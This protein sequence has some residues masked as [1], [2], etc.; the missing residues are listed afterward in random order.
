MHV[1]INYKI[2]W[3]FSFRYSGNSSLDLNASD[4]EHFLN[5]RL[6]KKAMVIHRGRTECRFHQEILKS[7]IGVRF[8]CSPQR[9]DFC[10]SPISKIYAQHVNHAVRRDLRITLTS[11][12]STCS[13]RSSSAINATSRELAHVSRMKLSSRFISPDR[14]VIDRTIALALIS[15]GREEKRWFIAWSKGPREG[16]YTYRMA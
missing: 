15:A 10:F 12:D 16:W 5:L 3:Q 9:T 14:S 8:Q 2:V 7:Y 4:H 1:Y 6:G 11:L 13:Q